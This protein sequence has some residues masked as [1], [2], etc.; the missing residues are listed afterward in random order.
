MKKSLFALAGA[1]SIILCACT[2][3]PQINGPTPSPSSPSVS[4]PVENTADP[5]FRV[6]DVSDS[7]ALLAVVQNRDLSRSCAKQASC[8]TDPTSVPVRG[9][10]R[11]MAPGKQNKPWQLFFVKKDSP[12]DSLR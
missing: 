10:A 8:L 6:I 7:G 2:V 12:H 11:A 4:Q 3:R 9:P 1:M 5:V